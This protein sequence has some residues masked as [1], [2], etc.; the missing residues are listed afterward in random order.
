MWHS[1]FVVLGVK[2]NEIKDQLIKKEKKSL[3]MCAFMWQS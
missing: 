3:F 1:F 2:H